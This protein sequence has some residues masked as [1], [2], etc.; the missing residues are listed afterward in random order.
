MGEHDDEREDPR[1]IR[2]EADARDA[3]LDRLRA[4]VAAD[5]R[6]IADLRDA[7]Q[8]D[9]DQIDELADDAASALRIERAQQALI[10]E[11]R[12]RAGAAGRLSEG[13]GERLRAAEHEL[14]DLRAIRD[15]L[16]PPLLVQREGMVVAAELLPA[17]TDVGGDFFFVGDGPGGTTVMAVGDVVGHGLSAARRCAFTRTAL[18]SVA[19]FSDD[20]AQLLRWVN[21]A[22]VERI[23]ETADFVT[24][25]CLVYDPPGRVL[26]FASAGHHPALAL[27]SGEELVAPRTGAALG[28]ARE[29]DCLAGTRPLEPGEGAL[30]FT[31]G[32]IEARGRESRYGSERL[33]RALRRQP[34]LAP[35][36]TI[37]LLQDELR[38]FA[39]C[40]LDD[41]VCLLALRS[42]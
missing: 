3:E 27:G 17:E 31:D 41:D 5:R 10:A 21:A 11:L 18:A 4:T 16:L 39:G 33:A 12:D 2:S 32:V 6:V 29:H 34:A 9:R 23:G 8:R 40:D 22:L 30:L 37:A 24:V 20:P 42:S 38:R 7:A 15:A 13:L 14:V 36:E 25:S 19:P 28:I 35:R 26:R 1:V